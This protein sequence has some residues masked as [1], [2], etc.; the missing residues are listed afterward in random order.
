MTDQSLTT[1]YPI[2][3]EHLRAIGAIVIAWSQVEMTMEI[4]ICGLYRIDPDR[5]LVLTA[6]IGFQS[7]VSLLRILAKRGA[8]KDR[9]TT[10][11]ALK[12]L[13][14]IEEGYAKRNSAAH[15]VWGGTADPKI[16]KRMSI[17]AR[18]SRLVCANDEVTASQLQSIVAEIE[19]LR[20]D[21]SRLL[22]RLNLDTPAGHRSPTP[23]TPPNS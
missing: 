20:L 23:T 8:I 11:A 5:G 21:F 3:D 13:T 15:G 18:G 12:I 6:N 22:R 2:S 16:A 4:A 9:E 10:A 14:R 7:R 19:A 1:S 17:R